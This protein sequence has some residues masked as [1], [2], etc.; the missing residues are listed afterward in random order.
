MNGSLLHQYVVVV[1]VFFGWIFGM[2]IH[3]QSARN[4]NTQILYLLVVRPRVVILVSLSARN[5]LLLK[6]IFKE[7]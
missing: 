6:T 4:A 3:K 1:V 7:E 2:C 5:E